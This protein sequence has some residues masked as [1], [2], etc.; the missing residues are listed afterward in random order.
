MEQNPGLSLRNNFKLINQARK[1]SG[2]E[3]AATESVL[4]CGPVSRASGDHGTAVWTQRE[5]FAISAYL[6]AKL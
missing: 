2:Q 1:S 4:H 5:L 6:V 3:M